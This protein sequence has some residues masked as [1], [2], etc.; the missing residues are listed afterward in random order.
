MKRLDLVLWICLWP[1]ATAIGNYVL[2][3]EFKVYNLEP[4]TTGHLISGL[5]DII[6]WIFVG[7]LIWKEGNKQ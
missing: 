1:I 2:M 4:S 5:I 7:N 3:Q 6:I